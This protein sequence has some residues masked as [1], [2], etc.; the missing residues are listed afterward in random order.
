MLAAV[1]QRVRADVEL[2]RPA[3]FEVLVERDADREPLGVEAAELVKGK[4]LPPLR[5][6]GVLLFGRILTS[7]IHSSLFAGPS[8]PP[9]SSASAD[10]L[11]GKWP[12][13]GRG[14]GEVGGKGG[15]LL[16]AKLAFAAKKLKSIC[17]GG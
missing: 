12:W 14:G 3:L 8:S 15:V 1:G 2:Q 13:T 9:S 17:V 6:R 7:V 5:D 10:S 4:D 16:S 11:S